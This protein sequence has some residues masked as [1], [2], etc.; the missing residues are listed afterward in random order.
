MYR[1]YE[2]TRGGGGGGYYGLVIIMPR[3]QTLL[4]SHDN[5]RIAS[6][7]RHSPTGCIMVLTEFF[8][9]FSFAIKFPDDNFWTPRRIIAKFSPFMD[10]GQRKKC[11]VSLHFPRTP[12][13]WKQ[14]YTKF[15]YF[16]FNS[17]FLIRLLPSFTFCWEDSCGVK[18]ILKCLWGLEALYIKYLW[19]LLIPVYWFRVTGGYIC[20]C[21][22]PRNLVIILLLFAHRRVWYGWP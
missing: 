6:I 19:V 11:I 4:P 2:C 7:F 22:R 9:F 17:K 1:H 3:P 8:H 18:S 21:G 5:H 14:N 12:Q 10:H 20:G 13:K 15:S 16:Y